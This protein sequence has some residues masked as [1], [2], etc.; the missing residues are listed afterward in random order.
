MM[1]QFV[2]FSTTDP[3]NLPVPSASLLAL[4]AT[5]CKVSH[6][7]G[8]GEYIK[9]IYRDS[10]DMDVLSSDGTS[11]DILNMRLMSMSNLVTAQS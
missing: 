2:T 7:S 6:L 4:H 3:Q 5:C 1:N 11:G 9:K 10:E 8:A